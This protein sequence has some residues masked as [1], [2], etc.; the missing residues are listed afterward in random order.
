MGK[1]K[2]RSVDMKSVRYYIASL[3]HSGCSSYRSAA[4]EWSSIREA[5]GD[6]KLKVEIWQKKAAQHKNV[7]RNVFIALC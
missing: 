3:A 2:E 5:V 4:F 1:M 7:K 6:Y